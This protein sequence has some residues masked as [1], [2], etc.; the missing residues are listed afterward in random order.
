MTDPTDIAAV[1]CV[2]DIKAQSG[3]TPV[4][5]G[6][7][8]KL[9]WVDQEAHR[10]NAFD[11]GSGTN[12]AWQMPAHVSSFA[13]RG[14]NE[15]ILVALRSGLFDFDRATGALAPVAAPPPYPQ[16]THRYNDGR[17]DRQGRYLIGSVDLSYYQSREAGRAAVY[18][19]DDRGLVPVIDDITCAN[20]MAFSPDGRTL[21]LADSPAATVYAFDYDVENGMPSNRR[22]FVTRDRADGIFDGAEVDAEGGYWVALLMK[23]AVA[24]YTPDGRLERE[25]PVP[26][27]QPTKIAFGG[28][29]LAMLY[30]TSAAH[31]H[32]PGDEPMGAQ[33]GGLF[34]IRTGLRGLPEARF[35]F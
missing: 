30:L 2:L 26:V 24:R 9:F 5:S 32:I 35:T 3:E 22:V 8:R 20:G 11:P 28:P 34:T 13:L 1:T 27:L 29:D 6:S 4:W 31:R 21:Y 25:I 33:A 10:L 18:R 15:P 14:A 23:G 16:D 17:C 19:L 12:E 7:E